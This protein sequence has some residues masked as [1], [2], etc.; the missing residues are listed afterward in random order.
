[1]KK[2]IPIRLFLLAPIVLLA[3]T[4]CKHDPIIPEV[5]V[6]Y[7]NDIAPMMAA[8]CGDVG[9]HGTVNPE[10]LQLTTYDQVAGMVT[11]GKPQESKLYKIITQGGLEEPMPP[12]DRPRVPDEQIKLLYAWILQGAKNN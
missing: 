8:N 5:V 6:S 11:P 3:L 9:C 7:T 4:S 12:P 1:M 2:R 10:E